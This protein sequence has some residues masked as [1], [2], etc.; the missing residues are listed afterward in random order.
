[1]VLAAYFA[2]WTIYA[3][4]YE[5][6]KLPIENLSHVI[7]A[8][9]KADP[10]SGTLSLSDPWADIEK[11]IGI[12]GA[13]GC[14]EELQILKHNRNPKLK[15]LLSVGGW[16]YSADLT[17]IFHDAK[18]RQN[19]AESAASLV[20][21]YALDGLD[22]DWEYPDTA[23]RAAELLEVVRLCRQ[24]LHES[25]QLTLAVPARPDLIDLL[26]SKQLHQLVDLWFLMCYDFAGSWSTSTQHQ[27][28]LLG[29]EGSLSVDS[30][31]RNYRHIAVP[32]HK[33]VIG[34]PLYG[35]SF[36]HVSKPGTGASFQGVLPGTYEN[37]CHDVHE[38]PFPGS[39]EN[40]DEDMGAAYCQG[41][42][43][44][45]TYDNA[46]TAAIKGKY[47]REMGLGG[48]MFWEASGDF[49]GQGS[50]INAF[51]RGYKCT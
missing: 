23:E 6:S 37:G 40:V 11:P 38:L 43:F 44:F 10:I 18:R 34:L 3:R 14:L 48:G 8:F 39:V 21:R 22:I 2:N 17:S 13:R 25:C 36:A 35:R 15:I 7:Y 30:V 9:A 4:N 46:R 16:T 32:A 31:V 27:A 33:L 45:I 26:S 29:P 49:K 12:H 41:K 28:N 50:V 51:F 47:A 5:P 24:V 19:F 20:H 42:D 1:M